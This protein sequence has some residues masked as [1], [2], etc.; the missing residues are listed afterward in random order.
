MLKGEKPNCT[1]TVCKNA[2]GDSWV[3]VICATTASVCNSCKNVSIK[4]VLPAPISPVITTKPS[5]NQIVDSMYALARACCLLR[6]RNCGSGL[7]RNGN[8]RSLNNS[9]YM[10]S[11][12]H[13]ASRGSEVGPQGNAPILW[14]VYVRGQFGQ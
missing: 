12:T 13:L 4:V 1:S 8:S 9:R 6:Y 5:V 2:V 14:D 7:R 3:W 10:R 11:L